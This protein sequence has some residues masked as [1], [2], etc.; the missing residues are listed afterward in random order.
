MLHREIITFSSEIHTQPVN[1]VCL[2][3][4]LGL[5]VKRGGTYCNHRAL[6]LEHECL[7]PFAQCVFASHTHVYAIYRY[8]LLNDGDTF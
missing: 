2:Q 4:I 8:V 6:N 1:A 3:N 5:N 7:P